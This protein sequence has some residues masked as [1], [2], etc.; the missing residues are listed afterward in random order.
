MN[1]NFRIMYI[2]YRKYKSYFYYVYLG[3]NAKYNEKANLFDKILIT[4]NDKLIKY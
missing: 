3:I 2:K 1:S 4:E